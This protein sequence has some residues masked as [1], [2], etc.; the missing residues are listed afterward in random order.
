[1]VERLEWYSKAHQIRMPDAEIVFDCH[2]FDPM[3]TT[4]EGR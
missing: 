1:M 2:W 3:K 4:V